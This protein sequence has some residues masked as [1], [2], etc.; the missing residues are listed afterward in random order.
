MK[1][2]KS[3]IVLLLCAVLVVGTVGCTTTTTKVITDADIVGSDGRFIY[4]VVYD[5][6]VSEAVSDETRNLSSQLRE[7]FFRK[8]LL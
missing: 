2:L 1:N 3:I 4:T 8:L 7:T 5:A 6:D